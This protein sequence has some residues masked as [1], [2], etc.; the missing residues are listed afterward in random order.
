MRLEGSREECIR[1]DF[2]RICIEINMQKN[3]RILFEYIDSRG[4]VLS[5]ASSSAAGLGTISLESINSE[6]SDHGQKRR[7]ENQK[8]SE[9]ATKITQEL[10]AR[11]ESKSIQWNNAF[12]LA[13]LLYIGKLFQDTRLAW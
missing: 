5:S 13:V 3:R 6:A 9:Q 4:A 7:S 1:Q 2:D 8:S 10:C 12:Q 11:R